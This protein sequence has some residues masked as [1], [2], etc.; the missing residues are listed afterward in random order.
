MDFADRIAEFARACHRV[1]E[2]GL[3]RCSSGNMSQRLGEGYFAVSATKSWL[4]EI[5]EGQVAI[6]KLSDGACVNG[7]KPTIEG[8]FH[9]GILNLRE[10]VNVALH[11]QSPYATVVAC[12]AAERIDFNVIIEVPAYIGEPAVVDYFPPGSGELAEAVIEAM[13]GHEVAILRNHGQVVVGRD[14]DDALQKA[15]F[16]ELACR[17]LVQGKDVKALSAE[18]VSYLTKLCRG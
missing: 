18:S 6:C 16:F 2:Y 12:G 10:D 15:V 7:K 11:C 14:F 1:G 9:R 3:V 5:S 17:V 4:G 13:R 8:A